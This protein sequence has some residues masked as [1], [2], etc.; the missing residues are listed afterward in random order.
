MEDVVRT[1]GF[2]A[3]GTRLKRLGE[4]L[5]AQ[6]QGLLQAAGVGVPAS[7]FPLLAALDRL[8][9]L[10]VGGVAEALGTSQPGVTR[11]IGK[12]Q[13]L[14]LVESQPAPGDLRLR[15]VDLTRDGRQLVRRAKASLWPAIEAA[16]AD[17]SGPAGRSL[18]EQLAALEDALSAAD[19]SRRSARLRSRKARDAS[20]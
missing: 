17:A 16:V 7:H 5:Q 1:L 8:G 14:G 4:R 18:L 19:L 12:L 3:L 15:T 2:L 11:Q 10:S 13:A 20:A 9:P 6:T